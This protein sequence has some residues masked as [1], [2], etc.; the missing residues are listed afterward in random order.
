MMRTR[1]N[2]IAA[3]IVLFMPTATVQIAFYYFLNPHH[4]SN[5]CLEF[6][7]EIGKFEIEK[8]EENYRSIYE[9]HIPDT[10]EFGFVHRED[11]DQAIQDLVTAINLHALSGAAVRQISHIERAKIEYTDKEIAE[12]NIN[13]FVE[14]STSINQPLPEEAVYQ[15]FQQIADL[16]RNHVS[17]R[18]SIHMA[19][20]SGESTGSPSLED[21]LGDLSNPDIETVNTRKALLAYDGAMEA[22][23]KSIQHML[24]F[25]ALETAADV[26]GD[27]LRSDDLEEAI[28]NVA[29]IDLE[30]IERWRNIYHR[31]KHVDRDPTE[32][33]K[34]LAGLTSR[35]L[36][37]HGMRK[38]AINAIHS[39]LH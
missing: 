9:L 17:P 25:V 7:R 1:S 5:L 23:D 19:G 24:L 13:N 14:V 18:S 38:A 12:Y 39:I 10:T 35:G 2:T 37:L 3:I 8:V 21:F 26:T 30:Y 33:R 28:S 20:G 34:S 11:A 31:Q 22:F 36:N 27:D 4:S 16:D 6:D 32:V 15:T 29:K